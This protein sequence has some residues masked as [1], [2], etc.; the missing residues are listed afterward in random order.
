[1]NLH[2]WLRS[3]WRRVQGGGRR[4]AWADEAAV[5]WGW[6][7]WADASRPWS[8]LW[9]SLA[10]R[11]LEMAEVQE[12]VAAESRGQVLI[13]GRDDALNRRFLARLRGMPPVPAGGPVYREGFFTLVTLTEASAVGDVQAGMWAS[14]ELDRDPRFDERH[15]VETKWPGAS[16]RFIALSVRCPPRLAGRRCA[17]VYTAAGDRCAGDD[18]GGDLAS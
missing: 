9:R 11:S 2:G 6:D 3:I 4:P 18:G 17:L 13:M 10:G 14:D 16:L 8:G 12:E 1:M 15:P 7:G 5:G